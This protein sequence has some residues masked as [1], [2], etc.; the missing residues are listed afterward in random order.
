MFRVKTAGR[1]FPTVNFSLAEFGDPIRNKTPNRTQ[2]ND[3]MPEKSKYKKPI[4]RKTSSTN[5]EVLPFRR[6]A[7]NFNKGLPKLQNSNK[8]PSTGGVGKSRLVN[9]ISS[10]QPYMKIRSNPAKRVNTA[11][12]SDGN[13]TEFQY[14]S[15][16]VSTPQTYQ[17]RPGSRYNAASLYS[18]LENGR[19]SPEYKVPIVDMKLKEYSY[20]NSV[21]PS[22]WKE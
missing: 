12:E 17:G 8:R 7:C 10:K 13:K 5:S 14:K 3:Y 15:Q 11:Q 4:P 18:G 22:F 9:V 20:H 1:F 19:K 2:G 16:R 21:M 6:T